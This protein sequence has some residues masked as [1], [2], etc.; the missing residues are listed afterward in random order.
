MSFDIFDSVS[1]V[2]V[3]DEL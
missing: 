3:N 2:F 1:N